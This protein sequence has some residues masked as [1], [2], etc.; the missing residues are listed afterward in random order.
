MS[1]PEAVIVDIDGTLALMGKDEEGR[2]RPYDW[3]RVIE[4]DPN[5]PIIELVWHLARWY[6]LIFVSGRM[7]A[8]RPGTLKWLQRYCL[9]DEKT[10]QITLLMRADGDFRKDSI[11]KEEIYRREIEGKYHV[12]Y[13]LDDRDQVVATWR[14]LGLTVLQVADGSF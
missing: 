8:A 13:V 1:S 3:D 2:R 9:W 12:K 5:M 4:D 10:G 11:V 7:E 6:K 14:K